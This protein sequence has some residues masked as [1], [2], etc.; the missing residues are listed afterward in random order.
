M[1]RSR[2]PG[3]RCPLYCGRM[4]EETFQA[5]LWGGPC[6]GQTITKNLRD[7][8]ILPEVHMVV[9]DHLE[10]YKLIPGSENGAISAEYEY[11]G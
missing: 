2:C 1:A 3:P 7:G 4:A 11:D 5:H 8:Q 6:A 10:P 9:R